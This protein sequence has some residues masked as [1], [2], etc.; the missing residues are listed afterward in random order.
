[1]KPTASQLE[2]RDEPSLGLVVL[3]PAGCGK[4]EALALRAA[5]LLERGAAPAPRK[6]LVTTFT[7]RARDNIRDRLRAHLR[8]RDLTDRVSVQNFHGLA[9]RIFR[10]HAAVIGMDPQMSMPE[11]DWVADQC[12][13]RR[14]DYG[15]AGQVK[16]ALRKANQEARDDTA[17]LT[18]LRRVP[19]ALAIEQL[20]Q[21]ERQ[22]TYDDLLRY[23]ELIL[24]DDIVAG[25]YRSHFSCVIVDEFQD[26]TPQQLRVVQKIGYGRTTYA[27]DL[28]QG[29]YGFAGADPDHAM[30]R[31]KEEAATTITLNES[32]RS[33]PA[34][35]AMVNALARRVG[36]QQLTCAD[37]GAWPGGGVVTRTAFATADAE[38]RWAL[39]LARGICGRSPGQRV[40]VIARTAARR[41]FIDALAVGTTDL[42]CY[43]WDDPV[44]DTQTAPLLRQTLHRTSTAAY[45]RAP[46]RIA[47]LRDLARA[48]DVQDPD[49]RGRLLDALDWAADLLDQGTSPAAVAARVRV[50][51]GDTLLTKPGLHL[52]TG[53]VGKGQQFDWVVVIGL[54]EGCLPDFRAATAAQAAEEA[55]ILS[56]MI[57]RARHGLV[58]S[59][60]R[61]VPDQ[62]GKVRQREPSRLLRHFAGV[63][64]CTDG[65]GLHAWL[66]SV[67]EAFVK[68]P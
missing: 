5:G 46:D 23:A 56:V 25:L 4:T 15:A 31:I 19:T 42:D 45:S 64:Q 34:V 53:H 11:R 50:G 27:G 66:Q 7:N 67:H 28:A 48:H 62:S 16:D 65:N 44:L 61:S 24:A 17:V 13:A 58:L 43:R 38:A 6:I 14:L 21:R 30:A 68:H 39:S 12:R 20:R 41:R 18:A 1:V 40:A 47:Y 10:A 55:R 54:E 49:I 26:L 2:I 51:D 3:A 29:I 36:G 9:A 32:H 60:A 63:S 22:V 59:N 8:P 33:S 57:S 35:L 52:L 37:P